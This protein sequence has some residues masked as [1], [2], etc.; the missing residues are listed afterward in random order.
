MNAT[1][2][3][4]P[5][6]AAGTLCKHKG[7]KLYRTASEP[8]RAHDG[9]A[10][11]LCRGQRNGRGFGPLRYIDPAALTPVVV[12]ATIRVG[13]AAMVHSPGVWA[14]FLHAKRTASR[15][16]CVN[17]LQAFT[18][19]RI[20]PEQIDAVMDGHVTV[21]EEPGVPDPKFTTLVLHFP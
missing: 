1:A 13:S 16:W 11:V 21:T 6:I 7:G 19:D 14:W 5:A 4:S 20:T 3:T 17:F 8:H 12:A 2:E 10:L 15:A 18:Q 9:R